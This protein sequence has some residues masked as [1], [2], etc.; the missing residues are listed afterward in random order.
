MISVNRIKNQIV[1]TYPVIGEDKT[2]KNVNYA[3][4]YT[5]ELYKSLMAIVKRMD[6]ATDVT[7]VKAVLADFT[8]A[9]EG[10]EKSPLKGVTDNI[11]MDEATGKCYL[12]QGGVQSSIAMPAAIKGWIMDRIDKG[13]TVE[14]I[15]N[16]WTRLLR[17]P[18]IRSKDNAERFA[19]LVCNYVTEMRT[20]RIAYNQFIEEGYSEEHATQLAQAP[21]TPLTPSGLICTKKVVQPLSDKM[22]Y[23]YTWDEA[24]GMSKRVLQ[25]GYKHEVDPETGAVS[26]VPTEELFN[27]DWIFQ[28]YI[29]GTGGDAFHCGT[30]GLG[31]L[32]KVGEE[33]HLDSWDQVNCNNNQSCVKGLECVAHVVGI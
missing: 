20:D 9:V 5:E 27:E 17:N 11:F 13:D 33:C 3:L 32:I 23:T 19:E 8:A 1:G 30:R 15:V 2:Q 4:Q 16:F 14:P 26:V 12:V 29:M 21:Q 31:H 7:A 18:N 22:R 10:V 28:P 24:T 6:D 25:E